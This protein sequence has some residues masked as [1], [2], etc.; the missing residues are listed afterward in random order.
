MYGRADAFA[1]YVHIP[2]CVRK[3]PYCDF[4]SHVV[5]KIPEERYTLALVEELSA[6]M[7]HDYWRGR[8]LKSI[9][10]GGG[11][12]STFTATSIGQILERAATSL[13]FT[14]DI[15]ITLEANPGSVDAK[16][17]RQYRACGINRISIGAQSFQPHLL[18]FLGRVH[19]ADETRSALRTVHAAGFEN[20]NIDLMY[21]VP[22]QS[23]LDLRSDLTEALGEEPPHLSAYNL[24]IE[25]GTPFHTAYQKGTLRTLPDEA[26]IAMAELV[27][28]TLASKGLAR[29]EI[30]NYAR[31]GFESRHNLNYWESGDYLGIG[32]G[33][34]SYHRSPL[35]DGTLGHRWHNH[36][37][38]GQYMDTVERE[39]RAV[40][41]EERPDRA[42]AM[43][44]FMFLG[45][46]MTR[47]ISLEAF[48]Q[49]FGCAPEESFPCIT[50]WL[51]AGL[52]AEQARHIR[53]TP[54]GLLVA[55][56]LFVEFV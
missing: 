29:Y 46:R 36:R 30:S 6:Q 50:E 20:F 25:E 31:P 40:A 44:E 21:A 32:A 54:Q 43:G 3:C 18:S 47:G 45:L 14:A 4:N 49:L 37:N 42:R 38:P 53:L 52:L 28:D 10:F 26:E 19:Q 23:L 5:K 16:N 15:E 41:G 24:T 39:G 27:E 7:V 48:R 55:N 8:A 12:P 33:A 9:F 35:P 13:T 51:E 17:F 11:T 1:L 2:Y 34:H 56:E 22:G